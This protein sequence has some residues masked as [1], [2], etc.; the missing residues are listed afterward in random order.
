[1]Q[2]SLDQGAL[3][4]SLKAVEPA[5]S[6]GF[7]GSQNVLLRANGG[8]EIAAT[9]GDLLI[10][11]KVSARVVEEGA[12]VVPPRV[13][14][15]LTALMEGEVAL[16][17]ENRSLAV[18]NGRT[19]AHVRGEESAQFPALVQPAGNPL[20][21]FDAGVLG[22]AFG[23][24]A[25][26][27]ASGDERPTLAAVMVKIAGGRATVAAADGFCLAVFECS[28]AEAVEKDVE[29][30]VPGAAA[31]Q[32]KRLCREDV[33][34]RLDKDGRFAFFESG[35]TTVACQLAAGTYPDYTALI[36]R[37]HDVRAVVDRA[38]LR[39][40]VKT[41]RAIGE[42]PGVH[43][44]FGDGKVVVSSSGEVGEGVTE[45]RDAEVEGQEEFVVSG[46]YLMDAIGSVSGVQ[47]E[48]RKQMGMQALEVRPVVADG[49]KA[50]GQVGVIMPMRS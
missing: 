6:R 37:E 38:S 9:S 48:L 20:A 29:L 41:A 47:V 24:V 49:E 13:M 26:C 50:T 31:A 16:F 22:K 40:A 35:E 3:H 27:V 7:S 28:L 4:E 8:L 21:R 30:L 1:M 5:V 25:Y 2:V 19:L 46:R 36:P 32:V 18:Q 39:Q 45:I 17:R 14:S 10:W 23:S 33:T 34:V 44:V 43:I 15:D 11:R 12:Y 42:G